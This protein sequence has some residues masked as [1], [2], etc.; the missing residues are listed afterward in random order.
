MRRPDTEGPTQAVSRPCHLHLRINQH[1]P[2]RRR[3]PLPMPEAT[4]GKPML[5]H[6]PQ[7]LPPRSA[8]A[9]ADSHPP[10]SP[11]HAAPTGTKGTSNALFASIAR[12]NRFDT[13]G[14]PP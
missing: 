3:R 10:P 5:I 11:T 6:Q 4:P 1:L 8:L 7:E 12:F 9:D 2:K 13:L 14:L